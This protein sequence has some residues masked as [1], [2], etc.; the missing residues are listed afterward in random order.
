VNPIRKRITYANVMSSIAVFLVLGGSAFAATQLG[1]N[2]VGSKQLKRGAV[3]GA[4]IK[5]NA[6]TATKIRKG[7]VTGAKIKLSSLGT[8][9]SAASAATAA[10]FAGYGRKGI[11]RA[12]GSAAGASFAASM[13][14]SP[15]IPMLTSGP[16]SLY[17]KCFNDGTSVFGVV[18][19]STSENSAVFD[20][21]DDGLDGEPFLDTTTPEDEREVI[22]ESASGNEANYFGVHSTEF[23]AMAPNGTIVR[24][25]VQVAVKHGTLPA[26]DGL[27]GAGNVC[28]FGGE[29]TALNG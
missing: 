14:A 6:I 18:L 29:L 13:A 10:T 3:T 5:R 20:S 4:K 15:A 19:A 2:S 1:K 23:T 21:D 12:T 26:G 8:V 9:P 11:V 17:A 25:D 24:G 7:A 27:Y 22:E 16:I 28:L